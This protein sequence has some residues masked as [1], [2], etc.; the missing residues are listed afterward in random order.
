MRQIHE[1]LT[2]ETRLAILRLKSLWC[3]SPSYRDTV[4]SMDIYEAVL[5]HGIE[6]PQ[7]VESYLR[8][9]GKLG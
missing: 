1:R 8:R 9:A 6:R 7:E 2:P 3:H 4:T 5:D